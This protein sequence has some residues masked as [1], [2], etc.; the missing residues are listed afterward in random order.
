DGYKIRDEE[1]SRYSALD[2]SAIKDMD[3]DEVGMQAFTHK[4]VRS[5]FNFINESER[6]A[7]DIMKQSAEAFDPKMVEG[8]GLENFVDATKADTSGAETEA[9]TL[10]P[11][12]AEIVSSDSAETLSSDQAYQSPKSPVQV[13]RL[14]LEHDPDEDQ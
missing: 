4:S 6:V 1:Q 9:K 2:E 13:R 5:P 7:K 14:S 3:I 10:I 12:V 11:D 8:S